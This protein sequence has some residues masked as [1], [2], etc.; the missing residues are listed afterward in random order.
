MREI[1]KLNAD[2]YRIYGCDRKEVRL[3]NKIRTESN[4]SV[5]CLKLFRKAGSKFFRILY[6]YFG[7]RYAFEIPY[8]TNIGAGL[9]LP[10]NGRRT[11]NSKSIIGQNV[12]IGKEVRGTRIG[13]PIIHDCVW[14]GANAVIVG[15]I[16]I[17]SNVLIAPGAFVN[18]DVP[19]GS[20]VLGNPGRIIN[21]EDAV[22]G[23]L[24]NVTYNKDDC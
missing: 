12:T 8:G 13:A 6:I 7:R 1:D 20:I 16:T 9:Y 11:I 24:K 18:F 23:Y 4:P 15:G 19:K 14:I 17:E 22:K 3:L 21:K 2:L 5:F 10:H